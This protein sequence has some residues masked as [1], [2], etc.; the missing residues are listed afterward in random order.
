MPDP[1]AFDTLAPRLFAV[2]LRIT[3]EK[4]SAA[5]ALENAFIGTPVADEPALLRAV[6]DCALAIRK[7]A[8]PP[9]S[10][11]ATPRQLVE[12]AFFGGR[13]VDELSTIYGLPAETVRSMLRDGM[14]QL[15]REVGVRVTQ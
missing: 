9:P 4:E 15:R 10:S 6:R 7:P 2:A 12:E 14:A 8:A 11:S 5:R 1:V 3:G 13:R